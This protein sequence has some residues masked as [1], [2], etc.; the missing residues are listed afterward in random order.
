PNDQAV[1]QGATL[2]LTP[3]KVLALTGPSGE[4]KSTLASLITRLYEPSR[5]SITLDGM[6]IASLNPSWLRRQIGVV[7]QEPVLFAGSIA[8]NIRYGVPSATGEEI[9]E[10]ARQVRTMLV[11]TAPGLWV[12]VGANA[13]DFIMGFPDGYETRVGDDGRQL[14]GGQKQASMSALLSRI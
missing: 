3:G 12:P 8:D 13:H 4:G 5:G 7:D 1:L 14:S 11:H 10:A 2:R 9:A 6:D